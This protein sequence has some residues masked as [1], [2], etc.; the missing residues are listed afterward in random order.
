VHAKE[1]EQ[2]DNH[3]LVSILKHGISCKT[4][5]TQLD[6]PHESGQ[7]KPQNNLNKIT[8]PRQNINPHKAFFY[9]PSPPISISILIIPLSLSLS[10][11]LTHTHTHTHTHKKEKR[12]NGAQPQ[13]YKK[14]TQSL[15]NP[16]TE[17]N[18]QKYIS[19]T[20]P[21]S[22]FHSYPNN[23]LPQ[24]NNKKEK[25]KKNGTYKK[26]KSNNNNNIPLIE[27]FPKQANKKKATTRRRMAPIKRRRRA[28]TT[29]TT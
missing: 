12:I 16:Q 24:H 23:S 15:R 3:P 26:K 9:A 6:Q 20:K 19:M 28:T 18:K 27:D 4:T 1:D 5:T 13:N 14:K 17:A 21:F 11:S 22:F 25:K 8:R 10:L 29:T 7:Q 2:K